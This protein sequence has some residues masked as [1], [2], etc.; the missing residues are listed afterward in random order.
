MRF[1]NT[2]RVNGKIL[3]NLSILTG[4]ILLLVILIIHSLINRIQ[5][6]IANRRQ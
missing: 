5:K 6:N 2:R 4:Q 3:T 1:V